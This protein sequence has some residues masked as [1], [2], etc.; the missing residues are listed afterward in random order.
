MDVIRD[1]FF[2]IFFNFFCY[3][4]MEILPSNIEF[5]LKLVF[6][7]R[8]VTESLVVVLF[9][10]DRASSIYIVALPHDTNP[11]LQLQLYTQRIINL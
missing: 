7:F 1:E 9:I 6:Y 4:T 8:L 11:V 3:Q 10:S 2:L 5:L